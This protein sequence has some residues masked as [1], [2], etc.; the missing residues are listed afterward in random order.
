MTGSLALYRLGTRLL[1][2]VAPFVVRSQLKSGK[3]RV[4]RV[5]ERFGRTKVARPDGKLLWMH[6]AS[7]GEC[8]L[9]L[10]V[11][12]ALQ[13][14][15]PGLNALVTSQ[16]LT[17][18]DLVAAWARSDVIHQMAPVDGPGAVNRFLSHWQPTAA[19]FAEGEIWPNMLSGAKRL[20]L[21]A[22]LI[23]ARMTDATLASWKKRPA[24]AKEIFSV[25]DFIGAADQATAEG[26]AAATGRRIGAVGNLK[27]AALVEPPAA[28]AVGEFRGAVG[29]R[30]ILLAASTHPGEDEVALEAFVET[31]KGVPSGLLVLV[32]RHPDRGAAIAGMVRRRGMTAQQWSTSKSPP[33][34]RIDVLV[35]DT[36]GELMFWY[37][38]SDA[39]YLGGATAEG[40]GGHNPI[41]PSQLGKRVFTGPHGFN[42]RETF[43]ALQALGALT[44][45][46]S[47]AELAAWWIEEIGAAGAGPA[48]ASYLS[49]AR[50]PFEQ[51]LAA[52]LGLLENRPR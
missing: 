40:I 42:F 11:F 20:G 35:A 15:L 1:E 45:G 52:I 36:I 38:A 28:H 46:T 3:E 41:E 21:R 4:D 9:L 26:L 33:S 2:P 23:N 25:F 14:R 51:S 48:L 44:V 27:I 10:D 39:V 30:R 34:S 37:A 47:A 29:D 22:A 12:S 31:R 49:S 50:E 8:R 6:G 32:P 5:A 24:A 7:I 17:S 16:T 18:A 13:N 19:V 43:D